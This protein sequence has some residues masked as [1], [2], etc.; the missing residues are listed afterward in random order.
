MLPVTD[1]SLNYTRTLCFSHQHT[2]L[3][4]QSPA[5]TC[6]GWQKPV[7]RL[8]AL[9]AS[10]FPV[11]TPNSFFCPNS[12]SYERFWNLIILETSTSL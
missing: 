11:L 1:S 3:F 9:N 4:P 2:T 6:H 12:Y 8:K 7:N 10:F 5:M